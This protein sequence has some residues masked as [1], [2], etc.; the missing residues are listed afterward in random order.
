[1]GGLLV[2]VVACSLSPSIGNAHLRTGNPRRLSFGREKDEPL[3]EHTCTSKQVDCSVHIHTP[4]HQDEP[5]T[6]V[7]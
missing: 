7:P 1:M 6:T 2:K 4:M 5:V 3:H